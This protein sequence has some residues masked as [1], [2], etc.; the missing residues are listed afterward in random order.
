MT[1]RDFFILI[2]KLFGLYSIVSV[3]FS[4]LP[5]SFSIILPEFSFTSILFFIGIVIIVV[6][7]FVLLIF[8][9]AKI[10]DLLHLDKGFDEDKIDLGNLNSLSIIKIGA[11]VIGG[12]L[13]L[14]N[15]SSFI[16]YLVYAFKAGQTGFGPENKN[17][18]QLVI[19][20]LNILVGYLLIT[21][22]ANIAKILS[23]EE[24]TK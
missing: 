7:I 9:S 18:F 1:K 6:G 16:N 13:F 23:K 10:V 3:L 4:V 22:Y 11:I 14:N 5:G 12:L 20:G 8:K 2:L 17:I 21:N 19:S 15:I 24:I